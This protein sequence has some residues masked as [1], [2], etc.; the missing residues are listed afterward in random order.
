MWLNF[1]PC[2]TAAAAGAGDMKQVGFNVTHLYGLTG[3][4]R[5]WSMIGIMNGM[6]YLCLNKRL[7]LVRVRYLAP[8]NLM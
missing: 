1:L 4:A 5:Q 8:N 2:R 6:A 3:V 7:R